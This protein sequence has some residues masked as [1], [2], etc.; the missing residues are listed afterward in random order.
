ML[1]NRQ[2]KGKVEMGRKLTKVHKKISKARILYATFKINEAERY[3]M[4]RLATLLG[5]SQSGVFREMLKS[6][7]EM[8]NLDID[9]EIRKDIE[10]YGLK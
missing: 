1:A 8:Y 3:M 6:Y 4:K 10:Y 9:E 2:A 7:C 5:I